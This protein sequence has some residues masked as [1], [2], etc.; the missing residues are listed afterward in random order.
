MYRG[1]VHTLSF[2]YIAAGN[3]SNIGAL[4][5]SKRESDFR[6]EMGNEESA[7]SSG[8]SQTLREDS[9]TGEVRATPAGPHVVHLCKVLV[10][11]DVGVGKVPA[12]FQ[13]SSL[14][15]HAWIL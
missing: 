7:P 3:H 11:G 15:P 5:S 14:L 9:R 4:P 12:R 6:V 13:V 1:Y 10:V 2:S 8:R